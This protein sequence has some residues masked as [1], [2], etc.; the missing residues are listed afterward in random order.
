[1]ALPRLKPNA[2]LA[3]AVADAEHRYI[4]SN[5]K[6][7]ARIDSAKASMPGGNT[8]TVLHYSP[9]PVAFK[10]GEGCPLTDHRRS[11][12]CGLPRRIYRRALRALEP[13][14]H[15]GDRA[16]RSTAA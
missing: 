16:R 14:D 11:H 13:A 5:P 15:D 4:A 3:S 7:K 9:F 8:R 1:M 12:L 2:D 6:S 10:G